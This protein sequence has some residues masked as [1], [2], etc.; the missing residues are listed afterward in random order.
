[1]TNP[2]GF[3]GYRRAALSVALIA[4]AAG[5]VGAGYHLSVSEAS[6]THAGLLFVQAIDLQVGG[7][8]ENGAFI[9]HSNMAPGDRS[10]G[11]VTLS[12][13][14]LLPGDLH[15][16]DF[17]VRNVHTNADKAASLHLADALFLT[18]LRYRDDDLLSGADKGRDLLR[19][20]DRNPL[21]GNRDGRLSL[22]ELEA[23]VNDL[24]PPAASARGGSPFEVEVVFD[25]RA[26]PPEAQG[27]VAVEQLRVTFTWYLA[28][29]ND[30]DLN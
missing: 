26:L 2:A 13:G 17:D 4:F 11:V 30:A 19:E 27:R 14:A 3:G 9:G 8:G 29:V 15:D 18:R 5:F 21:L 6:E 24:P 23:G 10:R 12:T 20:I 25:P 22:R 7:R 1:V 16:L 28:S